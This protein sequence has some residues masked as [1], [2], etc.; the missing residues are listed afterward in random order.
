[1]EVGGSFAEILHGTT[2]HKYLGRLV[3]GTLKTRADTELT[4][5]LQAAWAKFHKHKHVLTNRHVSVKLRLKYFDAIISPT[6]LFGLA[7]LPLTTFHK[8]IDV[9]QRRM[10]RAI[11]GWVAVDKFEIGETQCAE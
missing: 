3:P 11:V 6:V 2:A 5:R 10:I 8:R 1:M 7:S 4:H 9:V